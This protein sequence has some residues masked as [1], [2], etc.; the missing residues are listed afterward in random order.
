M[1]A[2]R[3]WIIFLTAIDESVA[4]GAGI[5]GGAWPY[6]HLCVC[7]ARLYL[8]IS[9]IPSPPL[10]SSVPLESFTHLYQHHS[11]ICRSP[12]RQA[13]RRLTVLPVG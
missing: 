1:T 6:R 8:V 9:I 13:S 7:R 4:H 2:P 10:E 12:S 11:Q 5:P 3:G